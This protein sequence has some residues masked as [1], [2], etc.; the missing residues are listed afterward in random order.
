MIMALG[1][2]ECHESLPLIRELTKYLF[3]HTT[4]LVAVGE[5]LVRVGRQFRVDPTPGIEIL[6]TAGEYHESLVQGVMRAV[7]RLRLN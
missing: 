7:A 3:Y 2:C 6:D 4:V 5:A 1:E